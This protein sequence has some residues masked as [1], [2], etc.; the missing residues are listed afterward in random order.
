MNTHDMLESHVAV[1]GS[2]DES[3]HSQ[4]FSDAKENMRGSQMDEHMYA[5]LREY[6]SDDDHAETCTYDTCDYDTR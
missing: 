3:T 6:K 1:T 5:K 2:V 4:S